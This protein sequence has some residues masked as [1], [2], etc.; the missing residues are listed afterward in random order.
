MVYQAFTTD[1]FGREKRREEK[2]EPRKKESEQWLLYGMKI[3]YHWG[4]FIW[5]GFEV[6]KPPRV[7]D[8]LC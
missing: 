2:G 8:V 7:L 6:E 3:G 4:L 1:S 5:V